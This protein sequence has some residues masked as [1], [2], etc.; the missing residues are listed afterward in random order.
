MKFKIILSAIFLLPAAITYADAQVIESQ[1]VCA[2]RIDAL[3]SG[4]ESA[5]KAKQNVDASKAELDQINKLPS[6]LSP[7]EKQKRIPA[8]ANTDEAEKQANEAL[9]DRKISP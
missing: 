8:L 6:S 1:Q 3:K 7:C 9:E 5:I 4:L 2:Q